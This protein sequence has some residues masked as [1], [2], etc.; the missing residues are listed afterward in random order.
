M[1]IEEIAMLIAEARAKDRDVKVGYTS[2]VFDLLHQ[3]HREFIAECKRSCN[4]LVVGVDCDERVRV[5]KGAGRPFQS[6]EQR[7][8]EVINSGCLGFIKRQQSREY[9][10]L[11]APDRLYISTGKSSLEMKLSSVF[12]FEV[13]ITVVRIPYSYGVSTSALL[14]SIRV[15]GESVVI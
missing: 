10:R 14:S 11:Y 15:G 1:L 9:I 4:I 6:E 5:R 8:K 3:G 7:L 12:E 13:V 2:G